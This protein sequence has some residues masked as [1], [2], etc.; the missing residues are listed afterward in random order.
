VLPIVLIALSASACKGEGDEQGSVA[1]L[2][3]GEF[4]RLLYFE[5]VAGCGEL[6]V[7][8]ELDTGGIELWQ[9]TTSLKYCQRKARVSKDDVSLGRELFESSKLDALSQDVAA[10]TGP[11]EDPAGARSCGTALSCF[12]GCQELQ[13]DAFTVE[14][15]GANLSVGMPRGSRPAERRF[16][17]SDPSK[18]S[19][20]TTAALGYLSGLHQ[21]YFSPEAACSFAQESPV[22]TE[23]K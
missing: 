7:D 10:A 2:Q 14:S 23:P 16:S 4:P 18:F 13:Q 17:F 3:G 5:R 22:V 19:E 9:F 6:V 12:D 8:V 21:K 1:A 11:A 15:W 20:E